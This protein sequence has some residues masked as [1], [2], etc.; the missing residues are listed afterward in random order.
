VAC[1]KSGCCVQQGWFLWMIC[2]K[3][4]GTIIELRELLQVCVEI[5]SIVGSDAL[6]TSYQM[7][8]SER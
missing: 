2:P 1:V 6:S 8:D 5:I 4:L 3:E 7:F